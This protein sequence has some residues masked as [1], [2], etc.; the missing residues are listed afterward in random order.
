MTPG[1]IA[2]AVFLA[3]LVVAGVGVPLVLSLAAIV[4]A[5]N[6]LRWVWEGME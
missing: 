1:D 5:I 3:P 6:F 2:A 4:V